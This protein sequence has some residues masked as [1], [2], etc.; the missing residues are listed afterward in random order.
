MERSASNAM[1]DPSP[2]LTASQTDPD[3]N[4]QLASGAMHS[5]GEPENPRRVAGM[6]EKG[7]LDV[8]RLFLL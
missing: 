4:S 5:Q 7:W 2:I 8:V 6:V 3:T 1:R